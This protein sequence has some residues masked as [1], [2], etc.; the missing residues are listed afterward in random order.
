MYHFVEEKIKESI[1]NGEFD[2]LPGKGKPLHLKEELQGLSP[3]IRRAYK[4]LKNAGYIPEEQ[5]KKKR[6]LTFNDL[7]T[8]A[9]G[10]T[11]KTESLQKKQLEELVKKRELQKNQTFRTYAQKIYKKL[12]NL[13]N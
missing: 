13:Q 4:I 9:T 10:K 1:D 2:D 12:L 7:Y 8:F 6:S 11:R 3:E 5:E